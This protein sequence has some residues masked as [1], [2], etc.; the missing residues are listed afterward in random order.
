M[1]MRR[2]LISPLPEDLINQPEQEVEEM[3]S[4]L[5]EAYPHETYRSEDQIE[6]QID[7]SSTKVQQFFAGTKALIKQRT[8]Y[9]EISGLWRDPSL[10]FTIVS[11]VFVAM[12]LLIGGIFQFNSI[13]LQIP[14]IYNYSEGTWNQADKAMIFIF[15]IFIIAIESTIIYFIMKL[16]KFDKR[17]AFTMCWVLTILN[18]LLLIAI[19]QIYFLIT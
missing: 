12:I 9:F 1:T 18:L 6:L 13:P 7:D 4:P 5:L 16:M 10:P 15:P 3:S 14:F 2:P 17:L 19:G 11:M 8:K